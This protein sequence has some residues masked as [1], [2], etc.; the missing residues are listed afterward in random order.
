MRTAAILVTALALLAATA[1]TPLHAQSAEGE[2]YSAAEVAPLDAAGCPDGWYARGEAFLLQRDRA[3]R[4]AISADVDFT[5]AATVLLTTDNLHFGYEPGT[6]LTL[7]RQF[8]CNRIELSYFGL[9][10]FSASAQV[11]SADAPSGTLQSAWAGFASPATIDPFDGADLHRITYGSR[12]HSAEIN[13]RHQA[14]PA[15]CL[16]STW[17][18]GVR[19][20]KVS[21]DFAFFSSVN[22]WM[23]N[24]PAYGTYAVT[25]N[26][27][28]L[29]GQLG[30]ELVW[31]CT[32]R[33]SLG[34]TAKGA[35][36]G[37]AAKKVAVF[38]T[39]MPPPA[40]P[41]FRTE[42]GASGH[43]L[44]SIVETGL[45]T[46]VQLTP[47][48]SARAGYDVILVSGL[49]LAPQQLNFSDDPGAAGAIHLNGKS[50]YHGPSFGLNVVW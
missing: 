23:G 8:G 7:G 41:Y 29:G 20:L 38:E 24:G 33:L 43:T 21:E 30:T 26:N 28:L 10:D 9:H 17:L 37:S 5:G 3:P 13:L 36:L 44:A 47:R 4:T 2:P 27:D 18:V 34:A 40:A 32:P 16:A 45:F 22:D 35:L 42:A 46:E 25:T 15:S 1:N 12:L 31:S 19:Y 49:A 48:I 14:E 11:T 6:R 39:V 50:V